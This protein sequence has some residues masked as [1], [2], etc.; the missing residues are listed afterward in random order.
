MVALTK[1]SAG[2]RNPTEVNRGVSK[3]GGNGDGELE[4]SSRSLVIKRMKKR[5]V[6]SLVGDWG[7]RQD[8]FYSV[9]FEQM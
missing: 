8:S 9:S 1:Q 4:N 3:N 7:S 5:Q 6:W 2:T